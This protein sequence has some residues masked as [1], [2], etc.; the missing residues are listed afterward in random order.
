MG[1]HLLSRESQWGLVSCFAEAKP[2]T[3]LQPSPLQPQRQQQDPGRGM[4]TLGREP[5]FYGGSIMMNPL[6]PEAIQS[7]D[8]ATASFVS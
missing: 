4:V 8:S 1:C 2:K 3:L 6:H 7:P 5:Q